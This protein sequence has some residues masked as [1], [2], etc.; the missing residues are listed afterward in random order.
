MSKIPYTKPALGLEQQILQL[1]ARGMV[2][3]DEPL[4]KHY[5]GYI[6][7]YRLAAYWLPFESDH[8]SH[9]FHPGTTFEQVLDR[10]VFDRELRLLLID[11]IERVEVAVRTQ[12]AYQLGHAHGAHLLLNANLFQPNR[13]RW[14]Y[15]ANRQQ[16][17]QDVV[18]SKELFIQHLLDKYKEP[19]PP[20]WAAVEIMTLG[21]LSKWYANLKLRA[22]R[23][24]V[25]HPFDM[26]ETN[27][28]SFLHHLAVVRNLCAH[29]SRVWNR[30]LA[31]TF[32]LPNHRPAAVL[33]SLNPASPKKLYNTL[34][35]LGYLLDRVSPGH[36]W[37]S[38]LQQLIQAHQIPANEMGFPA[39]WLQQPFW[40]I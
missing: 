19:L 38:R 22:D 2:I 27:L 11:A 4:A 6:N 23:N 14:S 24:R 30:E 25:A 34:A 10:Y 1:R 12:Y 36:H 29:H 3:A 21:Q 32:K 5:L 28:A 9:Q 33:G 8:G 31:F 17:E 7:Y 20:V 39:H 15:T 13:G 18:N 40:Q 16:L 37:K 35:I 26:D